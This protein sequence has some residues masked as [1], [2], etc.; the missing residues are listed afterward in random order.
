MEEIFWDDIEDIK[1]H[2]KDNNIKLSTMIEG[3]GNSNIIA[4]PEFYSTKVSKCLLEDVDTIFYLQKKSLSNRYIDS[5]IRNMAEQVIEYKYIIEEKPELISTYFGKNMDVDYTSEEISIKEII[6]KLKE[7]GEARYEN[8][9][10]KSVSSMANKINEKDT[11]ETEDTIHISLYD[12]F[13]CEAEMEHNSYFNSVI[14]ED[15]AEIEEIDSN[16]FNVLTSIFLDSIFKSFFETYN[17]I[18]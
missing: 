13:S 7:S 5:I 15:V 4:T 10:R 12:I 8:G 6:D 1:S 14:N 2:I 18:I 3:K 9:K 11:V 16:D 17:K